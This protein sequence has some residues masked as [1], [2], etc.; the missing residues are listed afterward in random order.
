MNS[1]RFLRPRPE[2]A[3]SEE[4][5]ER[6]LRRDRLTCQVCGAVTGD[7]DPFRPDKAVRLTVGYITER[8]TNR[9]AAE[10]LRAECTNCNDGLRNVP[11]PRL[12]RI[13]LLKQIRR[14]A[15]DDQQAALEWLQRKF[16]SRSR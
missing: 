11:F 6:I 14:A 1:R 12:S 8:S 13:E 16:Q 10:N 15:I 4:V 3:V 2:D 7:P 5:C 9:D